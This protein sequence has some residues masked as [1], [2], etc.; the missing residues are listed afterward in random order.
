MSS[1]QL[2]GFGRRLESSFDL[3]SCAFEVAAPLANRGH[4]WNVLFVPHANINSASQQES[5]CLRQTKSFDYFRCR[6]CGSLQIDS[7]P[8]DIGRHYPSDYYS[9]TAVDLPITS[10]N[11]LRRF[12]R[13][14]R[15]DYYVNRVNLVGWA[16]DKF[17]H[18]DVDLNREW[19]RGHVST[20]SRILDVGCGYGELLRYMHWLGF[21]HLTGV[22]PFTRDSASAAG[23]RIV[24]G[25]LADLDERF[26]FV[27][28]HHSL[29]HIPDPLGALG[30]VRRLLRRG[31]A[32]LVRVPLAGTWGHSIMGLTGSGWTRHAI[33]LFRLERA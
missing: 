25:E 2:H 19:F 24:R 21:R 28:L 30:E 26:D 23:L 20:R 9:I 8:P 22:D 31:G 15:T 1:C 32:V 7:I 33:C 12:V 27:M 16:I 4:G 18:K 29:E 5:S 10:T 14:A 6:V 13:A 3:P 17:A 11:A